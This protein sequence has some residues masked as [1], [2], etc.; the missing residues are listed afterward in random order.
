VKVEFSPQSFEK[1]SNIKVR[2]NSSSG[3]R[4]VPCGQIDWHE[5]AIIVSLNFSNAPQNFVHF[6]FF[7]PESSLRSFVE[8]CRRLC[9]RLSD[10]AEH[11]GAFHNFDSLI[12]L[13]LQRIIRGAGNI[14]AFC[15][16]TD[17]P[18]IQVRVLVL[19]VP[20]AVLNLNTWLHSFSSPRL[21]HISC[22][23]ILLDTAY[24][25]CVEYNIVKW[26]TVAA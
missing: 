8:T 13:F 24:K 17:I 25:I 1:Y 11:S 18:R 6:V 19:T 23:L 5:K 22:L 26:P 20:V 10:L 3:I 9:A 12:S 21:P 2:Y 4:V 15:N 7:F 16:S 14:V